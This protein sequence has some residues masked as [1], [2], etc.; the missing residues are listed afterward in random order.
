M[1]TTI[2]LDESLLNELMSYFK[3]K[4]KT[5]AVA[6]AVKEQIRRAKLKRLANRLGR[7]AVDEEVIA[8]GNKADRKRE[9]LLNQV[10]V[11]GDSRE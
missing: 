5:A 7:I 4:T 9:Q 6:Q 1:R 10:G 2:T 11:N 3:A 8:N